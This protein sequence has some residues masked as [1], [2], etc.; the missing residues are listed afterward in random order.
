[1]GRRA[2]AGEPRL[3]DPVTKFI[4]W[5][6]ATP[7]SVQLHESL[8]MYTYIETA[9]VIGIM[10]FVGTIAMVDLRLL[11]LAFRKTP[12]SRMNARILPFTV[13]GFV[14]MTATGILLFYAIPMRT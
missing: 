9:H 8:Y 12:I 5:L 13:V 2:G 6:A 11:G 4:I 7:W 3:M 10:L 14:L 1:M